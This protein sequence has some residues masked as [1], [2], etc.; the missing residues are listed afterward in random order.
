MAEEKKDEY[1]AELSK[2]Q[3]E[4]KPPL[5]EMIPNL[6]PEI[7]GAAKEYLIHREMRMSCEEEEDKAQDHLLTVMRKAGVKVYRT[8]EGFDCILDV[9]EKVKVTKAKGGKE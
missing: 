4:T 3:K 6:I 8:V 5:P 2:P 9:K 7:E 1:L